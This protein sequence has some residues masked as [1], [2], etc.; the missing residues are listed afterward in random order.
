ML[1]H[2]PLTL[3][4]AVGT[5]VV[6]VLLYIVIPKGF[7]PLQDTGFI[8]GIT[9]AGPTVSFAEM[10][11]RQQALADE[12]LRDPD[13]ESLSSFIG[14]DGTNTTLNSGRFLI[15]LKPKDQRQR[16][17]ST[18]VIGRLPS[19][20]HNVAGHRALP[21]A[22]AGSDHRFDGQPRRNISSCWRTRAPPT[23]NQWVPQAAWPDLPQG[24]G[25]RRTSRPISWTAV[26]R[27][28]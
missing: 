7:F 5:L 9:Q 25:A 3:L 19:A 26:F 6:T 17:A 22:G 20:S 18:Q 1:D 27:P 28:M 8:Q 11:R 23:L 21:A 2:Q 4:V 24:A 16:R 10:A 14:V 13:V 12:L 15:N